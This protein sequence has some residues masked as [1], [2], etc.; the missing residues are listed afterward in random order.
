M[1][2]RKASGYAA[3]VLSDPEAVI[4]AAVRQADSTLPISACEVAVAEAAPSTSVRRRLAQTLFEDP[5]LLVSRQP[6]GSPAVDRLIKA[7]QRQGATHVALPL[8]GICHREVRLTSRQGQLRICGPCDIRERRSIEPCSHC[9]DSGWTRY[10]DWAGR[11][12][13]SACDRQFSKI[14]QLGR[15]ITQIAAVSPAISS[16][17]VRETLQQEIPKASSQRRIADEL[18]DHPLRLTAE[19]AHASASTLHLLRV[20]V[21]ASVGEF[22]MPPCPFCDRAIALTKVREQMRCCRRC[23]DQH[24]TQAC[25]RCGVERPVASRN[26]TGAPLC[27]GCHNQQPENQ[28]ACPGCGEQARLFRL[29]GKEPRCRRCQR[30][31]IATCALCG[32]TKACY[33]ADTSAPRCEPCSSKLLRRERCSLCSK[34]QIVRTRTTD[35]APICNDCGRPKATCRSCDRVM[36]VRAWLA[37]GPRCRTC[38]RKHPASFKPCH[39]CGSLEHLQHFGLCKRCACITQLHTVLGD[40]AGIIPRLEPVFDAL[41]RSSPDSTLTYLER[42]GAQLL[43][44]LRDTHRPITHQLLDGYRD[45]PPLRPLRDALVCA[46][47]LNPRDEILHSLEEQLDRILADAGADE[48][49]RL[50]RSYVTWRLLHKLRAQSTTRP[51]TR[52]QATYARRKLL[53]ALHLLEFL[54]HHGRRLEETDQHDIDLWQ[55][56]YSQAHVGRD[57][58]PWAIA[59]RRCRPGLHLA[60]PPSSRRSYCITDEARWKFARQLL[61]DNSID[62]CDRFAGLLLLLFAQPARRIVKLRTDAI[63]QRIGDQS[64]CLAL[65]TEPVV[66]PAPFDKLA[67][68]LVVNRY[69]GRAA[70]ARVTDH[71]WL[72]PGVRAGSSMSS[73]HLNARLKRFGIPAQAARTTALMDLAGQL[74]AAVLAALLGLKVTTAQ[75]WV[76]EV[77]QRGTYAAELIRRSTPTSS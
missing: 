50:L 68:D 7:L 43:R 26:A 48:D 8:C 31:P 9:G 49:R 35:G 46:G 61:H 14:D 13:C 24:R 3:E 55:S 10:R 72:F 75:G 44:Q 54:R 18:A 52:S 34:V 53:A 62:R 71:D 73:H 25:A 16:E 23:Y 29:G 36:I 1:P 42:G 51:I 64:V 57:F 37:D 20:L 11:P 28:A 6:L 63:T 33:F 45:Q 59:R 12:F 41:A 27:R 67:L 47:V 77:G 38:Y 40:D 66:L 15:L 39:H 60:P 70:L 32:R 69:R 65:G 21:D 74:P 17:F 76:T 19:A 58:L 4:R 2:N 30:A 5:G 56:S 22:V